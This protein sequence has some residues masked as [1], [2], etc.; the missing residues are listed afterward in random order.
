MN[1]EDQRICIAEACGWTELPIGRVW[2]KDGY[3]ATIGGNYCTQ[4]PDYLNDL[5]AMHEAEKVLTGEQLLTYRDFLV[6]DAFFNG[7]HRK[8][9]CLIL[10]TAEQRAR[11]LLKALGK[12]QEPPTPS[13]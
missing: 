13:K 4:L 10:L 2:V 11:A 3:H 6:Q 9:V 5:N 1:T 12:W 7:E 8:D